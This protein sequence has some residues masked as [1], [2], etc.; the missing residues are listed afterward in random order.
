MASNLSNEEMIESLTSNLKIED[1]EL[2]EE[3]KE[4]KSSTSSRTER[5]FDETEGKNC[6]EDSNAVSDA[7]PVTEEKNDVVDPDI[8]E[9]EHVDENS[10]QDRDA[11]LSDEEKEV[12]QRNDY[13][14]RKRRLINT[15]STL[16]VLIS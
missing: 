4:D 8:S 16:D 2:T 3:D 10:I 14:P 15:L 6:N 5:T 12:R 13:S 9:L 1:V 11:S 7:S